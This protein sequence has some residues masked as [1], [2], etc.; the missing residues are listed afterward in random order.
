[1]LTFRND[2]M[3]AD[4]IYFI[5]KDDTFSPPD[6]KGEFWLSTVSQYAGIDAHMALIKLLR[7]LS[8]KYFVEFHLID[9][10]EYWE[11][12]DPAICKKRFED[13]TKWMDDYSRK[14]DKLDGRVGETGETFSDRI[15]ALLLSKG[16]EDILKAF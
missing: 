16:W 13:Y 15:E 7:F 8:Q 4:P 12:N 5:F 2:G 11:T 6:P 10:S 9:E 1:M 14:L 3:L